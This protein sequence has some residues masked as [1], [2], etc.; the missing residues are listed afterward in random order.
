M[1]SREVPE[2]PGYDEVVEAPKAFLDITSLLECT[3]KLSQAARKERDENFNRSNKERMH[4]RNDLSNSSKEMLEIAPE[5]PIHPSEDENTHKG[6]DN[7]DE[8]GDEVTGTMA[9]VPLGA[10][11]DNEPR[12]AASGHSEEADSD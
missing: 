12:A 6:S 1:L 9:L 7:E 10:D 5:S 8:I 2:Y 11:D 4:L 3:S